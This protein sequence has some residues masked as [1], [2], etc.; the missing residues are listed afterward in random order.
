MEETGEKPKTNPDGDVELEG[1][2]FEEFVIPE[3]DA[4]LRENRRNRVQRPDL[5]FFG[6]SI[7]DEVKDCS[8]EYIETTDRLLIVGTTL[9]TF[10]AFRLLRHALE[11]GKP[12]MML[13]IGPTRAEKMEGFEKIELPSS[14]VLPEVVKL[15]GNSR[16]K[17]AIH[18]TLSPSVTP[19][20][21][22]PSP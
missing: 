10:S 17:S 7:P 16:I 9:A 1:V 2:H 15:L 21:P 22:S 8:Y 13:N 18:N 4:C 11:L 5:I 12:V 6:E 19:T 20:V 3:C 14:T